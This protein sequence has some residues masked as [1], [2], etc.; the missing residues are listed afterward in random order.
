MKYFIGYLIKGEAAEWQVNT[1]K[2][3]SEEFNTWK[4]YEKIPPHITVFYLEGV[5]DISGIRSYIK[6]WVKKNKIPGN[7]CISGFDHFD[8]RVIFAKIDADEFVKKSIE[9]L[10]ADFKNLVNIKNESFPNWHPHSTLAN[11]LNSDEINRIWKFVNKLEKPNFTI[12]FNN[13]TIFRYEDDQKWVVDEL[14]ELS[15]F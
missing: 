7:F 4:I 5:E 1:A 2:K 8:D 6:E 3:I 13:V 12:P 11:Q 15:Q 14:F 10:R 9:N